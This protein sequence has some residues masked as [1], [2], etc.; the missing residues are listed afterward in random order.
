MSTYSKSFNNLHKLSIDAN[1]VIE[2]F[3]TCNPTELATKN[4][5][6]LLGPLMTAL[7]NPEMVLLR[8][9]SLAQLGGLTNDEWDNIRFTMLGNIS[10]LST[11]T[12]DLK[13][14]RIDWIR[15]LDTIY[16]LGND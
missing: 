16:A 3:D 2:V 6:A 5:A 14:R 1:T 12:Q 15:D 10:L 8:S 7:Y 4:I 13:N 11:A 9:R